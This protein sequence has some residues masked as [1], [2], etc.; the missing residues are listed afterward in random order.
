M[1]S[2]QFLLENYQVTKI[3]GSGAEVETII[4]KEHEIDE[5]I[6]KASKSEN[7]FVFKDYS[8]IE[9]LNDGEK[10]K[11]YISQLSA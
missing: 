6:K 7:Y 1:T 9:K 2:K 10:L 3:V 5:E 4:L 11:T 8:M